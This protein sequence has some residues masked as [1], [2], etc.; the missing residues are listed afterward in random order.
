MFFLDELVSND[1]PSKEN[2]YK[3]YFTLIAS[4]R[5]IRGFNYRTPIIRINVD[6]DSVKISSEK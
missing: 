4:A 2:P 6:W 1:P 5:P 3:S